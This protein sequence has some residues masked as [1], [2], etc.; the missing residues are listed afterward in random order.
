MRFQELPLS[1]QLLIARRGTS[2][3]AQR[4]GELTDDHLDAPSLLE[5]WSRKHLLAHVGYNAAALCRLLEWATTGIQTPMY[6]S[7]E[8]R[9]REINEGATLSAAALRNLFDHTTS[10]L[11]EKWRSLPHAA[12]SSEVRTAQGRVVPASETIWMRSREVWVHAVDLAND[13]RFGDFPHIVNFTLL[14]DVTKSWKKRGLGDGRLLDATASSLRSD[15]NATSTT[16]MAPEDL[17]AVVRWAT[18][19]GSVGLRVEGEVTAP[20]PWL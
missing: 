15:S 5:G 13:G 2:Y 7:A 17:S 6:E 1:E 18:G 4:L 8:H 3:F 11:D 14:D 19:R 9:D 20:P 16:T 10:R 12:W